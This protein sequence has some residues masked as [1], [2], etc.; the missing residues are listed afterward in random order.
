MSSVG[1]EVFKFML[2]LLWK[3]K[4]VFGD[5]GGVGEGTMPSESL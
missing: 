2:S 5:G 1:E 3:G 4:A